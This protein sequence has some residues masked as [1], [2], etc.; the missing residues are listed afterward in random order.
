MRPDHIVS[1][2]NA[3]IMEPQRQ[4]YF[5]ELAKGYVNELAKK[6]GSPLTFCVTT[7][8]CQMNATD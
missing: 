8:G 5:M 2:E 6:K 3:P 7:F 4:F 1:H